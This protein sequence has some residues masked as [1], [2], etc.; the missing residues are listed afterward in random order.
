MARKVKH[1]LRDGTLHTGRMHKHDD[2]TVMT[3]AKMSD[4]AKTL[5]HYGGLSKKSQEKARTQ[6]KK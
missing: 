5:L 3:G 4:S 2:G 1:Y 6:W